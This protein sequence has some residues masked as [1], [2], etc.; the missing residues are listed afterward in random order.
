MRPDKLCWFLYNIDFITSNKELVNN[1]FNDLST[2]IRQVILDIEDIMK[3]YFKEWEISG[4]VDAKYLAMSEQAMA[5][6]QRR[7]PA[8]KFKSSILLF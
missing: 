3:V 1:D 7:Y 5:K 8:A 4:S 6:Y 2:F